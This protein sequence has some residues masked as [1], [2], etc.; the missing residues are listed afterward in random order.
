MKLFEKPWLEIINI[1]LNDIVV[2]STPGGDDVSAPLESS[3]E[4]PDEDDENS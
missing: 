1:G 2:T 4:F 3:S